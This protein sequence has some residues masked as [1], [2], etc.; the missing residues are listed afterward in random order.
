MEKTQATLDPR[1]NK[2]FEDHKNQG[3]SKPSK[4]EIL[5]KYFVPRKDKEVFRILPPVGDEYIE[6]AHFH[7]LKINGKYVKVY[8]PR[9]NDQPT[10]KKDEAGNLVKDSQ[11]RT[12]MV[13]PRCPLCEKADFYLN[14]QD[15]SILKKKKEELTPAELKIK[16]KNDALYKEAMKW[17]ADK[18]YIV[19]GID[20]GA[21]KDGVKFWRF[22]FNKKRQGVYDKLIPVLSD[23]VE[24]TGTNF[25]DPQKGIDIVIN[26]VDNHTP[27]GQKYRDVSSIMARPASALSDD[28][29][30]VSSWLNDKTTWRDVF[31]PKSAP[32]ITPFEYLQL[33]AEGNAPYWDDTDPANK[34]WVFPN[35]PD[36]QAAA[37]TRDANYVNDEVYE[38]E[39][40]YSTKTYRNIEQITSSDV[41]TFQDDAMDAMTGKSPAPTTPDDLDDLPF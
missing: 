40:S 32:K 17:S 1:L 10:P 2:M 18:Y 21:T 7:T 11:G 38:D 41:G 26:V 20:R 35:H 9:H 22:K 28:P 39:E 12:V 14:Q 37:N 25:T 36:L 29:V 27:T 30:I 34:K 31:K 5:S 13:R 19:R 23:Y 16:E 6:T 8:C 24:Q 4:E 15:K 33:A 3:K